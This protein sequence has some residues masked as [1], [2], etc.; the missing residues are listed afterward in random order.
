VSTDAEDACRSCGTTTAVVMLTV[1]SGRLCGRC[2]RAWRA[3]VAEAMREDVHRGEH[4]SPPAV[5]SAR[6]QMTLPAGRR[7]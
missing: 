5:P 7:R 1:P 4:R 3:E 6:E 2:F